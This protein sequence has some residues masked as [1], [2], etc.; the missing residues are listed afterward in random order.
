MKPPLLDVHDVT[1]AYHR[2]PVLW[3]IDLTIEEPR[4]VGI[5]GPNG[6]GKSTLLKAILGLVPLASGEVRLFGQPVWQQRRRIG[7]VPQRES[8]DWD[9]PVSVL[10]VVLMGTYGRLGWFRRPGKAEREL[11]HECLCKVGI[12]QLARQQIGQLSGGQQQR[13]FLA[14]ALAQQADVY[15]MDEPMAGVDAATEKAIFTLLQEIR[16][17]GKAVFVVHHDLRTVPQYFDHAIL[18]NVRL[19]ASGPVGE[20]FTPENIRR[21]YGGRLSVL[22]SA[23]DA[24][25]A[26]EWSP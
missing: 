21:A 8:V 3:D 19:V 13:T 25:Q 6:A 4:L 5:V 1:V 15:F 23:A 14:R 18:L 24:L 12:E 7:Y 9:F 17:Q 22:E 26:Q 20:V 10:D 16:Q 2:R 11:A